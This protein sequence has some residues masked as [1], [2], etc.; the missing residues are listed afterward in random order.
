LCNGCFRENVICPGVNRESSGGKPWLGHNS[1]FQREMRPR[2]VEE[3]LDSVPPS[4]SRLHLLF[5]HSTAT[6]GL[7]ME[8][9]ETRPANGTLNFL[10]KC[11]RSLKLLTAVRTKTKFSRSSTIA[12][13]LMSSMVAAD[14]IIVSP[15]ISRGQVI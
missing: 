2:R 9:N 14:N 6:V 8:F 15:R 7:H 13:S 1:R 10:T 4:Q 12:F 3:R 5:N 11:W